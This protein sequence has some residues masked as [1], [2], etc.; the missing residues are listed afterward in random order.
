MTR[1]IYAIRHCRAE[2]QSPDAPLTVE[3]Q[4]QAE[5]LA[6]FLLE[7]RIEQIVSSPFLRAVQSIQ[8]LAWRLGLAVETDPRLAERVLGH[9]SSDWLDRLRATFDD[10]DLCFSGGE[11][12]RVAKAR[13]TAAVEDTLR[14]DARTI[15]VVTHGN[16]LALLLKQFDDAIGF[17]HWRKL[18]N[19]DVFRVEV[20]RSG[21]VI[22][23]IWE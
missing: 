9:A 18:T 20:D 7:A 11:S 5:C 21:V 13:V 8:P 23:R 22:A 2:G 6:E 12:S 3:G 17:E 16:L 10:L 14:G 4:V 19:P 1:T 15:A